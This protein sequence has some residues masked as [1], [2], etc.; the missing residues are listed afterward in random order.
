MTD[1]TQYFGP[2]PAETGTAGG[3]FDM[4][5]DVLSFEMSP[6]LGFRPV[7]GQGLAVNMVTFEPNTAAPVH[8][9]SEEQVLLMLEG[10]LEFEVSGEKRLL[11]PGQGVVIPPHTPHGART[12]DT[13]AVE[14]DIF[15]PP[16]QGL[17]DAIKAQQGAGQS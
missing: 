4:N 1:A 11:R 7:I 15:H 5:A 6:G 3:W 17:L 14:V 16:R 2:E 9:H 10:E 8:A 13:P 12:Y